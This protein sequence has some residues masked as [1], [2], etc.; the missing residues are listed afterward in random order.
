VSPQSEILSL[1]PNE[2]IFLREL[3][4]SPEVCSY[5]QLN[6]KLGNDGHT[7]RSSKARLEV[8][9]SRLRTKLSKFAAQVPEIKTVH[10]IGYQLSGVLKLQARA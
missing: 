3:A 9:V 6:E 2:C 1:T 8:I 10:G 5:D 7:D 4:L